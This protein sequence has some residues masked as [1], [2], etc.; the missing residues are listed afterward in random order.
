MVA[1]T[2]AVFQA[3]VVR[4]RRPPVRVKSGAYFISL[5]A[6]PA[7]DNAGLLAAFFQER[8]HLGQTIEARFHGE[9]QVLAIKA[10]HK[11]TFCWNPEQM[12]DVFADTW[13]G[14]GGQRQADRSRRT[15]AHSLKLTVFG[16]KIVT[17][18]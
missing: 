4:Q 3:G 15:A 16:P 7:I 12:P 2:H 9:K 17:P 11:F 18:C 5:L 13:S 14:G 8:E 10:S 1:A 6:R